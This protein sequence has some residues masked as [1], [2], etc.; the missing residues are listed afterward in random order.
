MFP[1]N[2][3]PEERTFEFSNFFRK[4]DSDFFHRKG[5]VDKIR[6]VLKEEYPTK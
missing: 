5:E 3:Q 2:N 6:K 1:C 4:G